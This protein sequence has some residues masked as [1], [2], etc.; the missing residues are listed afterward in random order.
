MLN[1]EMRDGIHDSVGDGGCR[2]NRAHFT[3]AFYAQRVV[4]R[5][6]DGACNLEHGE[7]LR[8]WHRIIHKCDRLWLTI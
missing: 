3:S 5:W 4:G 2:R 6:R 1:A 7:E 8:F